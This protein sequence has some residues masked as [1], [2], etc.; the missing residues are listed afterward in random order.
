MSRDLT[1]L[2][3]PG[4]LG[5]R[6]GQIIFY[7]DSGEHARLGGQQRSSA[8]TR[9]ST[10]DS[11]VKIGDLVSTARAA[12]PRATIPSP[13]LGLD[14]PPPGHPRGFFI[15]RFRR[16]ASE[17]LPA[18]APAAPRSGARRPP[19]PAEA[20]AP[21]AAIRG[22]AQRGVRK[23]GRSCALMLCGPGDGV[24]SPGMGWCAIACGL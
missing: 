24:D 7:R 1:P 3:A 12:T 23:Q 14:P 8:E 13:Q 6:F 22:V 17:P 11:A 10:P 20:P 9:T 21:P 18:V 2:V 15:A 16:L 19:Q 4:F 5:T